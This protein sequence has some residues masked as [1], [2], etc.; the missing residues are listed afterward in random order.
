VRTLSSTRYLIRTQGT[1]EIL[2]DSCCKTHTL[3]SA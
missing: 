3:N 2:P 1:C